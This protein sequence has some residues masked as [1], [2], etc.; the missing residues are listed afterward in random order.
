MATA[1]WNGLITTI[2]LTGARLG[3]ARVIALGSRGQYLGA[4]ATVAAGF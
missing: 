4:S 2:G 1:A 3:Y